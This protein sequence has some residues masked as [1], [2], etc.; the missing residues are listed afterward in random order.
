MIY[1]RIWQ[2]TYCN[3]KVPVSLSENY[4]LVLFLL[5]KENKYKVQKIIIYNVCTQYTQHESHLMYKSA[6]EQDL[7]KSGLKMLVT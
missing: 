5:R 1:N 6:I 3:V 2:V 7:E 4:T